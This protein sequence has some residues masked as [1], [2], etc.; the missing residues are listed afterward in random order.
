V[1]N[2][3]RNGQI[4]W[5]S[6]NSKE[7]IGAYNEDK[8]IFWNTSKEDFLK[9]VLEHKTTVIPIGANV[10]IG[11]AVEWWKPYELGGH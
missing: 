9:L 5:F 6:Y 4:V 1:D 11:H 10:F 7:F 3:P 8:D 2:K